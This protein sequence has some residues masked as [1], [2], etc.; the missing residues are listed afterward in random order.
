MIPRVSARFAFAASIVAAIA[1]AACGTIAELDVKYDRVGATVDG[2]GGVD[3]SVI[4]AGVIIRDSSFVEPEAA[5]RLEL[6]P[7]DAGPCE[8]DSD[9]GGGCDFSQG[10]GCCILN[11]GSSGSRCIF[12]WEVAAK[13]PA[14]IFV[15]CR[16]DDPNSESACCWRDGPANSKMSVLAVSC[17]GGPHAC[18]VK[19]EKGCVTGTCSE[20]TCNLTAGP[21]T[22]GTCVTGGGTA[23]TCQ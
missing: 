13:C 1:A 2:G 9:D 20:N 19:A 15:G 12:Q 23:V 3:P 16:G 7:S 14:G 5:P 21:F 11:N 17:D 10:L 18:N 8:P 6:D 22:I 4:E